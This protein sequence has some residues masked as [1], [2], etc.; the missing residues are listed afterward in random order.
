M[1]E[2]LEKLRQ[3]KSKKTCTLLEDVW[4][5]LVLTSKPHKPN[6]PPPQHSRV[7][8]GL[9]AS[10]LLGERFGERFLSKL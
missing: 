9:V 4:K 3:N 10:L 8:G 7:N 1:M 2:F 6:P 5:V